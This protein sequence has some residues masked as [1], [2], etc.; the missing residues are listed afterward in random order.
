MEPNTQAST[1]CGRVWRQVRED[2]VPAIGVLV[3]IEPELLL[4]DDDG[5]AIGTA[6]CDSPVRARV[7]RIGAHWSDQ[8]NGRSG[9][10]VL[11]E[12]T[13]PA[14]ADGRELTAREVC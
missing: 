5:Q 12:L 9:Y 1:N 4:L 11:L 3:E 8:P 2:R 7:V 6:R 13:Q 10:H 14:R